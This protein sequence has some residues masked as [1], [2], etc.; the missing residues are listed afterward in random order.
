MLPKGLSFAVVVGLLVA[1]VFACGDAEPRRFVEEDGGVMS[2]SSATEPE[3][4]TEGAGRS[5]TAS[6][7]EAPVPELHAI[8]P[9]RAAVGAVGPSIVVTGNDFV[10]RSVV[11]IDGAPLATSFVS[12]TELRATIPSSKLATTG[13]LRISVGTAP[14]GGG[15][16]KELPFVVENPE[17]QITSLAPLSVIAG[18]G[19]TPL[20]VRGR[21]FV[22]GAK[23]VFGT[24]DLATTLVSSEALEA[25]VPA[26]LLAASGSV[27]VTVENPGPGGGA[28]SPISFTVSNPSATVTA[29]APASAIVGSGAFTMTVTGGGFVPASAVVLNGASLA[30]TYH[31]ATKLIAQVPA[32]SLL[33]AGDL[34]VAVQ[35][36]PPGGGPSAPVVLRVKYP[37]PSVTSISPS[38]ARAGSGP[39]EVTVVGAGFF[40]ASQVTFD[41]MPAATTFVDGTR[42]KATL[43][44]AQ[45]TDAGT[46]LVRVVNPAPGGGTSAAL[47]FTTTNTVPTITSVSPSSVTTGSPDL[48]VTIFGSGFV[49]GSVVR[50]NNEPAKTTYVSGGQL[51]A[52]VPANHLLHPGTVPITVTNPAPG[53]GTSQPAT[54]EVGCDTTGVHVQLA[55][56]TT[57]A[58]RTNLSTGGGLMRRFSGAGSCTSIGLHGSS[59]QPGRYAVV[60]NTTGAPV[61]L[62]AWADCTNDG[63]GDAFLTLYRRPT[64]PANDVERL[65]CAFWVSEGASGAGGYSSPEHGGSAYCPGLTKANGGGLQLGVCEKAVVHIQ[66][67][68]WQSTTYT[69][70]PIV[71]VRAE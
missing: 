65:G 51:L 53:G 70:P 63:K 40:P 69:P 64:I 41:G 43:T 26:S 42:V 71:K 30:T 3:P 44:A 7:D 12:A 46:I 15:A 45:L 22:A 55:K 60:Q 25:T 39:T 10:P 59:A 1:L 27:P 50:S 35:N 11:Q 56:G 54:I 48:T 6:S 16:S 52:I 23:V 9:S 57:Y 34:P 24:T 8:A 33:V 18:A 5:A 67:W 62:S 61:T 14:P 47:A 68:D 49:P 29:I 32:S 37:V 19:A 2:E 13:T 28:S 31:D 38:S 17:P 66:A 36:P 58:F 20:S 4:P 21:G